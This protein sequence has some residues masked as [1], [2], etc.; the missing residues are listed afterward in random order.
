M[1]VL[2]GRHRKNSKSATT[3]SGFVVTEE[4]TG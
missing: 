4:P 3:G 2:K 1:S